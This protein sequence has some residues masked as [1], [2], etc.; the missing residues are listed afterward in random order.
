MVLQKR[1]FTS[2]F[3]LSGSTGLIY[4]LLW[5]RKFT[6][7]LG[8]AYVTVSVVVASFM[9][10][11]LLGAW[12]IGKYFRRMKNP[13]RWYATLEIVVG[14]FAF[15]FVASFRFLD[16]G[17][18]TIATTFLHADGWR[19]LFS[20]LLLLLILSVPTAAMGAT[21]PLLVHHFTHEET[22]F[23][24]NIS[25]FYAINTFGAAA[26]VLL[27]GFFLI[28]YAGV[29]GGILA[30]GALNMMIGI[31]ALILSRQPASRELVKPAVTAADCRKKKITSQPTISV[32]KNLLLITAF[33]SGFIALGFE[34]SWTRALKFLIQSSTYSFTIIL[35]VFLL[36]IA[37]GGLMARRIM[38]GDL[39]S[40]RQYG[41]FQLLLSFTSAFAIIFLYRIAYTDFFQHRFFNIIFDFSSGWISGIL[42][43]ALTCGLVF[44]LPTLFMGILYPL[45]NHLFH[46]SSGADAGTTVSRI[47][48]VNT[49]GSIAGTL[50]AG[51]ILI[52]LLG[53]KW[54][55]I[56]LSSGSMLIG[57]IFILRS[58][59]KQR[60]REVAITAL[61]AA[62]LLVSMPAEV[63]NSREEVKSD[64]VLYYKE[65]LSA[66]VKVYEAKNSLNMSI[67]GMNIASTS[68]ALMQKEQ[69]I[70]H[71]PFFIR[72]KIQTALSV[73]LASGIST[74]AIAAYPAVKHVDCVELIRPVFEASRLFSQYNHDVNENPRVRLIHDDIYAFLKFSNDRYDLISSD[75]KL[76]TLDNANTTMLSSDYYDQ[77][78]KH[79]NQG[80]VFIQWIPLITPAS[81]F[82]VILH[83]MK[84]SFSHVTLFYFYP[85]DVFMVGT[86]SPVE[87]NLEQMNA[88]MNDAK[89]KAGLTSVGCEKA[90]EIMCAYAG[91]YLTDRPQLAVNSMN[92]PTLEFLFYRD[93]K[94]AD[95][96]EGGYR[97]ANLQTLV[98]IFSS[99]K[100][101]AMAAY[102]NLSDGYAEGIYASSLNF[103]SFCIDNF[104]QGSFET[105]RKEY[106]L[107]RKSIPF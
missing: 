68:P 49:L 47:Y 60:I 73:G 29:T 45:L 78:R 97:A 56:L 55:M 70:A 81:C 8:S 31:S 3:F 20:S 27:A 62:L 1:I 80:G 12:L 59:Q 75:G 6:Y 50:S 38:R 51:F 102:G 85:S 48:W 28:E 41:R 84:Q 77:C 83:T 18:G 19:I 4:Q 7:L 13:L 79:L 14:C 107:F 103:F 54:S 39:G 35:F 40:I 66:T 64:R 100:Q 16:M 10:G 71:L 65:G 93:W 21:L 88:V 25:W 15:C 37:F 53:L 61:F 34:I 32:S 26:G 106:D 91:E 95:E 42:I 104:R 69:L 67:D 63:L 96:K 58:S 82:D 87:L 90:S 52:P 33:F 99:Q 76:G 101:L 92:R 24:K 98:S 5:V 17:F 9:A 30:A 89:V 36:G 11:L 23:K 72:P 43:Y 94:K 22:T 44:L 57:W 86:E 105:G 74:D 2:L 46:S